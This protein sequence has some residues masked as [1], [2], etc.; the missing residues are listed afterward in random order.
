MKFGY[1]L[2]NTFCRERGF[3]TSEVV[4]EEFKLFKMGI[5]HPWSLTHNNEKRFQFR[6]KFRINHVWKLCMFTQSSH[7]KSS[8][9]NNRANLTT[10]V[11]FR[12]QVNVELEPFQGLIPFSLRNFLRC[13]VSKLYA[14]FVFL[15][16]L[17]GIKL[18]LLLLLFLF[19]FPSL[20]IAI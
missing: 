15:W 6:Q 19:Y 20:S 7:C 18:L 5:D 4:T 10:L 17:N 16:K 13:Q 12:L 3:Y 1:T 11:V 2:Q 9:K 8:L 14:V